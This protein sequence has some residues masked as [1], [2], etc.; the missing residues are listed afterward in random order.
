[1]TRVITSH[2]PAVASI[3]PL[4]SSLSAAASLTRGNGSLGTGLLSILQS[5]AHPSVISIQY[6]CPGGVFFSTVLLWRAIRSRRRICQH[7]IKEVIAR[8]GTGRTR[9]RD[10]VPGDLGA[11]LASSSDSLD[12]G[13][14]PPPRRHRRQEVRQPPRCRNLVQVPHALPPGVWVPLN[15]HDLFGSSICKHH[16]SKLK[17]LMP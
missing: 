16:G 7:L 10:D 17:L 3:I 8:R 9:T 12:E 6:I 1:M 13:R 5:G 15:A 4:M 2:T 11:Q 14:E